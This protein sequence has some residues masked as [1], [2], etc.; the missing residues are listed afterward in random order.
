MRQINWGII[1]LGNIA[2]E[3]AQAFKE[4]SNA[5]LLAA[6]SRDESRLKNLAKNLISQKNIIF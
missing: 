3:F 5:N 6:A 2:E 1:G 4:L